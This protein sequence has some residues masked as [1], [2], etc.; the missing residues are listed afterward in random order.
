MSRF[1]IAQYIALGATSLS[2]IG[3]ILIANNVNLGGTLMIL[4]LFF[5]LVSYL[6][7]GLGTAIK[8]ALKIAK[9]GWIVIP[10]PYDVTTGIISFVFAIVAF[11]FL[12][13]IPVRKAYKEKGLY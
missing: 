6:F 2:I 8:M 10:F 1:R 9:W 7:G 3:G 12:P 4:G 13:I 5:G 11:T